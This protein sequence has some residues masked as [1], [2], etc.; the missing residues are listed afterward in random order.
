MLQRVTNLLHNIDYHKSD[1]RVFVKNGVKLFFKASAAY[2]SGFGCKI[3]ITRRLEAEHLLHSLLNSSFDILKGKIDH[4]RLICLKA[5]KRQSLT[6]AVRQLKG[7]EALSH[8]GCAAEY[9]R[10]VVDESFY[11]GISLVVDRIVDFLARTDLHI[12]RIGGSLPFDNGFLL[13]FGSLILVNE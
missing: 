12:A 10:S 13:C 8:L 6:D 2:I 5:E 11:N 7:Q 9:D 3:Q 1:I 4:T